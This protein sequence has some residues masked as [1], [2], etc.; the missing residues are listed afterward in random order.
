MTVT[1]SASKALIRNRSIGKKFTRDRNE[2]ELRSKTIIHD[3]GKYPRAW[4]D[5]RRAE[6]SRAEVEWIARRARAPPLDPNS[7]RRARARARPPRSWGCVFIPASFP[8]CAVRPSLSP[9]R[10]RSLLSSRHRRRHRGR[11]LAVRNTTAGAVTPAAA[12]ERS[13]PAFVLAP[14]GTR[15]VTCPRRLP[16]T[17]PPWCS[18]RSG[19]QSPGI[20]WVSDVTSAGVHGLARADRAS[21]SRR[22]ISPGIPL[23]GTGPGA[24][25]SRQTRVCLEIR[26]S[27]GRISDGGAGL[28]N[29]GRSS[30]FWPRRGEGLLA[31]VYTFP[32]PPRFAQQFRAGIAEIVARQKSR[33]GEIRG[34][35]G[36]GVARR[37]IRGSP[38]AI[39]SAGVSAGGR[40]GAGGGG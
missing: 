30:P 18:R 32:P 17:S 38:L 16:A 8:P 3:A 20:Q 7:A 33:A 28:G 19:K 5:R 34:G 4:T 21:V 39:D 29:V 27:N 15:R 37:D 2:R 13:I 22:G 9:A 1:S 25:R 24:W 14:R 35:A 11:R 10:A 6:R 36:E 26:A 12:R 31:N 23:G 40:G